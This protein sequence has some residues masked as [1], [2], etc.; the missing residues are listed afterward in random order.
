MHNPRQPHK[1]V[2]LT[3]VHGAFDTRIFYKECLSL[4]QAGYDVV[5]IAPHERSETVHGV[6]I[7]AVPKPADRKQRVKR[8]IRQVYE[9]ALAEDGDL[10]HFHDPELIPVGMLLKLRGK[11]VVFDVHEDVPVQILSKG[12]YLKHAWLR[13]VMAF[14]ANYVEKAGAAVFDGIIGAIPEITRQFPAHK[15]MTL[16]N[17]PIVSLIDEAEAVMAETHRKPVVIYAG[18]LTPIRGVC[19]M[20]TAAGKLKGDVVLWLLGR[21]LHEAFHKACQDMDGWQ[22]TRDWGFVRPLEVYRFLKSAEIGLVTLHPQRNYLVSLPVKAFEYMACSLPMVMSD[23]PYW[24]NTFEGAALFV[25][26]Q[27]P[28]AIADAIQ[29]LLTHPEEARRLGETGRRLVEER[30]SWERESR[31]LLAFYQRILDH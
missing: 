31:K 18:G 10:Y 15:A 20:I 14:G 23:F 19:E 22:H 12:D 17:Y 28:Q 30:Y 29:Y 9:A 27:D 26:P 3:S 13:Q 2:H 16:H 7:H 25:D 8:T 21:W 24:R 5:L 1:V 6:R 11:T 4:H